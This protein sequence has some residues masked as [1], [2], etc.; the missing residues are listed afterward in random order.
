M[1]SV[2]QQT[3]GTYFRAENPAQLSD[4]LTAILRPSQ[5]AQ[6]I[7]LSVPIM[8]LAFL[9]VFVDWGMSITRYRTIP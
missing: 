3:G 1:R 4:A 7:L 5:R 8:M 6:S 9:L 2:A